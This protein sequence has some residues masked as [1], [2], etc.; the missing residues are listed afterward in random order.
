MREHINIYKDSE[1]MVGNAKTEE[2]EME[3]DEGEVPGK[4]K[5]SEKSYLL[6]NRLGFFLCNLATAS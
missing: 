2:Q 3:D 5:L 6:S 4:D 1:K